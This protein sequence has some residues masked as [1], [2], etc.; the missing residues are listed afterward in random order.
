M[1][2]FLVIWLALASMNYAMF[3]LIWW[4]IDPSGCYEEAWR[5]TLLNAC[6]S[7]IYALATLTLS[8]LIS[9]RMFRQKVTT[10][11][12]VG[13]AVLVTLCNI[14]I[15]FLI[16][17]FWGFEDMAH[18]DRVLMFCIIASMLSFVYLSIS[19]SSIIIRQSKRNLEMQKSLLKQQLAPHFVFNSLS[20]LTD[21]IVD[22]PALAETFTL[23]FSAIYRYIVNQLNS[24]TVPLAGEIQFI[25]DYCALLDIRHPHHYRF[26]IEPGLVHD[27]RLIFPMSIQGL[28]ENAVKH[29]SHSVSRPL[30]VR[31]YSEDGYVVV[32]NER[33]PLKQE[34]PSTH[35]IGLRNLCERYGLLGLKPIVV[36]D[37]E[38]FTVKV[39]IL[40]TIRKQQ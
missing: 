2:R 36:A 27:S 25:H 14:A 19:Y 24:E 18:L 5:E 34:L 4:L 37:D 28:V 38:I 29:N 23:K 9:K 10:T 33:I 3:F 39:P 35:K 1:K 11:R 31:I 17:V 16:D 32:S 26:D 30:H 7:G 13:H 40:P 12:F 22:D 15:S 20:T 8:E 6:Y 21:L